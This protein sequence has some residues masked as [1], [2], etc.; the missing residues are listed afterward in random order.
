MKKIGECPN[1]GSDIVEHEKFYGC[2]GYSEKK[3]SFSIQKVIA[4]KKYLLL[5]LK[6][7]KKIKRQI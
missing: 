5:K 6:I 3:C 4:K 2:R 1:C 7:L